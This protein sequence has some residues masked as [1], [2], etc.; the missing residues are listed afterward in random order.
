MSFL[1]LHNPSYIRFVTMMKRKYKTL[2]RNLAVAKDK[3]EFL[4]KNLLF[5]TKTFLWKQSP[6]KLHKIDHE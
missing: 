5:R 4:I 3:T 2:L 6:K 1:N